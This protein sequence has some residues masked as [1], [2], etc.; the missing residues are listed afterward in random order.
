MV[1]CLGTGGDEAPTDTCWPPPPDVMTCLWSSDSG[2]A[3]DP[4]TT[5]L[6]CGFAEY[7]GWSSNRYPHWVPQV[8]LR[9][10]P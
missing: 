6:S 8:I 7:R 1:R 10:H 4:L 5:G 9:M 3:A 2:R